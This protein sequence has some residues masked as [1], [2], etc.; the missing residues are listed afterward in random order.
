VSTFP[1]RVNAAIKD[2]ELHAALQKATTIMDAHRRS[3]VSG[4]DNYDDYRDSARKAKFETLHDLDSHLLLFEKNLINNGVKVHWAETRVDACD[5]VNGIAE[6]C[7]VKNIVKFQ[8]I[9][10]EE[11]YLNKSPLGN[12]YHV[13]ETDLGE[14]IVQLADE[15]P[16][17]VIAPIIHMSKERV[18]KIM[19]EKIDFPYSDD[20][21][22]MAR[23]ARV[24][25]R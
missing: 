25:L 9:V 24:K 13:V 14:Y 2:E 19:S 10:T 5:I 12:G 4:L 17:H 16:S 1:E 21:Q 18:G 3:A 22:K 11:I 15:R 23:H 6:K 7:N 20:I 8:S